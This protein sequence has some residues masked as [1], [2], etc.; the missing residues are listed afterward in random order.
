[1][2]IPYE[3]ADKD[4]SGNGNWAMRNKKLMDGIRSRNEQDAFDAANLKRTAG[5]DWQTN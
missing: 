3:S 1:M 2:G 5:V 4:K